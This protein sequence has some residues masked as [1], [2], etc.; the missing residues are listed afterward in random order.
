METS[1][2]PRARGVLPPEDQ[3]TQQQ[4]YRN[5]SSGGNVSLP[6]QQVYKNGGAFRG[7]GS[8]TTSNDSSNNRNSFGTGAVNGGHSLA[9]TYSP[10]EHS[11]TSRWQHIPKGLAK[12][13]LGGTSD[14]LG[15][16]GSREGTSGGLTKQH[17][18]T[19]QLAVKRTAI[20][21]ALS[22]CFGL[23]TMVFR[24]KQSGLEFFA[25]YLVE[26]SLSEYFDKF[27][28]SPHRKGR[29]R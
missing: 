24:G 15:D 18:K 8:R 10:L 25:G 26:Q 12:V 17:S 28:S 5:S 1:M 16:V 2:Y 13:V 20:S 7:N 9:Y 21:V 19:Y 4:Y 11:T 3:K 29:L 14:S 22:C 23:A 6:N 27:C